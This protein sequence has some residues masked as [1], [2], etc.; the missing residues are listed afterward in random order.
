MR[1]RCPDK[2]Y[3]VAQVALSDFDEEG[4][5]IA[6]I[7]Y[8]GYRCIVDWDGKDVNFFSRR[9]TN[10]G[11]PVAHPISEVLKERTL[12]FLSINKLRPNTR[13]DCEWLHFRTVC[14]P[15]IIVF[16][17]LYS[18]GKWLGQKPEMV[19]WEILKSLKY[20]QHVRLAKY[21]TSN[22]TELF[23]SSRDRDLA[24]GDEKLWTTEG[25][26]LKHVKSKLIGNPRRSNKNPLWFKVKWRDAASGKNIRTF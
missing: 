1:I 9:G 21:T 19:R 14:E 13:L 23:E 2:P 12:R 26:V 18:N 11:G 16:G 10:S 20:S 25:I 22:Y 4:S 15:A 17:I 7:K 8:D 5:Y 24:L 6:T 3:R